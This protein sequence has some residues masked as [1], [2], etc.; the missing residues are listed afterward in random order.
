MTGVEFTK[1]IKPR[2]TRSC[3][4][5]MNSLVWFLNKQAPLLHPVGLLGGGADHLRDVNLNMLRVSRL[6]RFAE[7]QYEMSPGCTAA[8]LECLGQSCLGNCVY[9]FDLISTAGQAEE[10][11]CQ[12]GALPNTPC[13]SLQGRLLA[14]LNAESGMFMCRRINSC[15]WHVDKSTAVVR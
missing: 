14:P 2:V 6:R 11:M 10:S 1:C 9:L 4:S 12:V 13:T 15:C 3:S 7:P 8:A 5:A